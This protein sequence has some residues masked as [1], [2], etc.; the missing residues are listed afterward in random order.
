MTL[1]FKMRPNAVH[2]MPSG[3][4]WVVRRAGALR[5]LVSGLGES[6]A[7]ERARKLA[8]AEGALAY[9]FD[10]TGRIAEVYAKEPEVIAVSLTRMEFLTD[11]GKR[12]PII[13]MFDTGGDETS[14]PADAAA[15]VA[16]L[17]GAHWFSI[18]L[19]QFN[20]VSPN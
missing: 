19:G 16:M 18:D 14:G 4:T 2:A 10:R 7:W 9:R 12:G 15:A 8:D 17:D 5:A 3:R 6:E 13:N 20:A 1:A 11:T